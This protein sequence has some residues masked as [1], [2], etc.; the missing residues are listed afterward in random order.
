[1]TE[2]RE[3]DCPMCGALMGAE[4]RPAAMKTK[5]ESLDRIDTLERRLRD[6]ESGTWRVTTVD[7]VCGPCRATLVGVDLGAPDAAVAA[8]RA[9]VA[10][11]RDE[12]AGD[13]RRFA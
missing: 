2:R 10:A 13:M 5:A 7:A 4:A 11:L 12:I 3:H 6:A 8:L 1:M 9:R